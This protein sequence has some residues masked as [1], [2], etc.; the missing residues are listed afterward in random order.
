MLFSDPIYLFLFLPLAVCVS[1]FLSHWIGK[2]AV[3]GAII[4]FSCVFYGMWGY[5]YLLILIASICLNWLVS[6]GLLNLSDTRRGLRDTLLYAG[7]TFNFSLLVLFK[8]SYFL[9]DFFGGAAAI[10]AGTIAIPIGISFY[11]FQQAVFLQEAHRREANV[12]AYLGTNGGMKDLI[13]GFIRYSAF[14]AFFPQLVIG[15]IVYLSEFAPQV[16]KNTFG[17]LG[18]KNLEVGT[19]LICVGLFKKLV[20]ADNL[21]RFIDPTFASLAEGETV[22]LAEAWA[23]SLGYYAQLYFDFS[24]YSDLAL[25][26]ARLFGVTLPINF[27]SPLKAVSIADFYKRWHITLSRV[28]A[29]FL[30]TPLSVNGARFAFQKI[31]FS[32]LRRFPMIWIPLLVN[33]LAIALW[34]GATPTFLLFGIIHGLWYILEIELKGTHLWKRWKKYSSPAQRAHLGR[35]TFF[36]PML[37]CFSLFRA[38]SIATWNNLIVVMFVPDFDVLFQ[39]TTLQIRNVALALIALSICLFLPNVY[40]LAKPSEPGLMTY[41]TQPTSVSIF[42]RLEWRPNWQWGCAM[43]LALLLSLWFIGRLPPFLYLGF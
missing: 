11:T 32:A 34:H 37:L 24:G 41:D 39:I 18:R 23:A 10:N 30:Y 27:Y 6:Y 16:A 3:L 17:K 29:R 8:Y 1:D 7:Q 36:I 42:S 35:A 2:T 21:A 28:I 15:P 22:H 25:G 31:S 20:I 43:A 19:L 26:S 12:V 13:P 14:I 4:L 40:E 38:D 5:D 9:T 33:F